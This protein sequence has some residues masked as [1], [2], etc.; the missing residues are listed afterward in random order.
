[1][2]IK[3]GVFFGGKSVEHEVSVITALQ[4]IEH[5]D[6]DK[7]D[8]IPIYISK[9]SQMYVGQEIGNI[10][11]YKN[12]NELLERS[13]QVTIANE[14][15]KALILR[16]KSAFLQKR[17]YDYFDIAFPI[18]HGTEVEGGALYGYFKSLGIPCVGSDILASAVAMNKYTTKCVLKENE[19]PILDCICFNMQEY[20]DEHKDII[21][22]IEEKFKLPVI[23]KP[24][25]S[26]SSVGI[27]I[28]KNIEELENNIE[29]AFKY[30]SKILVEKAIK[31]MK[32]V[33]C[34]VLGDYES[35][36]VS[37][38]EEPIKSE[39]I[40][41]YKDKYISGGKKI[42]GQKGMNVAGLKLP[43]DISTSDKNQIQELAKKTFKVLGCN[44]VVRIDF[45]IDEDENK[46][47]VNEINTIPGC[48]SFHLWR[49]SS[50]EY[51]ELLNKMIELELKRKR[52]EDNIT[53][54]FESNILSNVTLN[55]IKGA[56]GVKGINK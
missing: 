3:I 16:T 33:N 34:S 38:C 53:Y 28:A 19:I 54:S 24:V 40:L 23:V 17:E 25:D 29:D 41:S 7:Y 45:M 13:I 50:L 55:G 39:E 22:N 37:E 1:M 6:K 43:A 15:G 26:G 36:M 56:K 10:E 30:S 48:L 35:C 8:I 9:K 18:V 11:K 49:A 14:N 2:K 52:E 32:E 47:Y 31:N 4:A 20:K 5:I 51:K 42:G 44:G 12:I 21:S 27:A 46:I